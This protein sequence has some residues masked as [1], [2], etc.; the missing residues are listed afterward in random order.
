MH[1]QVQKIIDK[2]LKEQHLHQ[3]VHTY[4]DKRRR[5]ED[6]TELVNG[7]TELCKEIY[8]FSENP[9]PEQ[10]SFTNIYR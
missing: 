3:M 1:E 8:G 7:I 6:T 5:G 10:F 4:E 9:H 2:V